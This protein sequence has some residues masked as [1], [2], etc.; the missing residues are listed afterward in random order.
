MRLCIIGINC[1]TVHAAIRCTILKREKSLQVGACIHC[2]NLRCDAIRELFLNKYLALAEK[3]LTE[4]SGI[5]TAHQIWDAALAREL[6]DNQSYGKTPWITLGRLL[7][8]EIKQHSGLSAFATTIGTPTY[9]YLQSVEEEIWK[10]LEDQADLLESEETAVLMERIRARTPKPVP[11][12]SKTKVYDRDPLYKV[13]RFQMNDFTPH[14]NCSHEGREFTPSP[15]TKARAWEL[16]RRLKGGTLTA[17]ET[18]ELDDYE[19]LEHIMRLAKARAKR[20]V[21]L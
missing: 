2:C 8:R 7:S 11:H 18:A 12:L 5:L 6:T 15:Q 1:S 14:S 9:Y 3:V 4:T 20:L 13:E 19:Q 16:I 10:R 17:E 21:S